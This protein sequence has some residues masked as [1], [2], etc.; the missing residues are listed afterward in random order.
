MSISGLVVGGGCQKE[1][2]KK[3]KTETEE[4]SRC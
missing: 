4:F 2:E 1:G 3:K